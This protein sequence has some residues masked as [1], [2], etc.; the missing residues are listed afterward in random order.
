MRWWIAFLNLV[1]A[2]Q[3]IRDSSIRFFLA[4]VSYH[5]MFPQADLARR[6]GYS[7]AVGGEVGYKMRSGVYLLLQGGGLIGD[8]ITERGFLESLSLPSFR[9]VGQLA[10]MDE[11]GKIFSPALRQR[12]WIGTIRIGY[13]LRQLRLPKQNPN[14]GPYAEIG[15]G[16]LAHRVQIDKARSERLPLFE[17]DYLKGLDRLTAGWGLM[18][19]IGY[20]FFSNNGLVNF[21]VGIELAQYFTRSQRGYAYD[22]GTR[23]TAR[24]R[25]FWWGF[26]IG[27]SLPLY[28]KAP[29]E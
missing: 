3:S 27:W 13:I 8:K 28:E 1:W 2:Q 10:F 26:R 22:L 23:D 6:F 4:S 14:C 19:S 24:R 29:I 7:S 5:G 18:Q 15:G 12:G 25:D 21:I 20:R 16:Y 9:K 11:G 17:G